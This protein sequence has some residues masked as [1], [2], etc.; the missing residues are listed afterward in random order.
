MSSSFKFSH[1]FQVYTHNLIENLGRCE[2][3][4]WGEVCAFVKFNLKH[5]KIAGRKSSAARC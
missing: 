5:A 4:D 3:K 2:L 1:I